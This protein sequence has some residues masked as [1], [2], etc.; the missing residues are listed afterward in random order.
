MTYAIIPFTMKLL[1]WK[2]GHADM[3]IDTE[4]LIFSLADQLI[5][6]NLYWTYFPNF[7]HTRTR[8]DK[9]THARAHTQTH[10]LVHSQAH[11][12]VNA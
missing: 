1:S 9:H 8:I 5:I 12:R 4:V 7:V 11:T 3:H 6:E 2:P 10:A